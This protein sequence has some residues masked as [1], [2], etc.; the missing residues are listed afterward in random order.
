MEFSHFLIK[1]GEIAVK[2]K[3]RN[4]FEDALGRQIRIALKRVDGSFVVEKKTG[5]FYVHC[6]GEYDYDGAV[7]ALQKIFGIVGI[8]PVYVFDDEGIE[9]LKEHTCDFVDRMYSD[10]DFTFKVQARRGNK[11]FPLNSMEINADVC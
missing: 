4:V 7:E 2:G 5:R 8:C 11:R 6:Q 3:N 9:S 1:Y 10:K